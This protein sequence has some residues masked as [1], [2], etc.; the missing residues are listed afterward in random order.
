MAY[1]IRSKE[2][3]AREL[4]SRGVSRFTDVSGGPSYLLCGVLA[5]AA[6]LLLLIHAAA[7]SDIYAVQFSRF[8]GNYA[9]TE[10]T[11]VSQSSEVVTHRHHRKHGRT[12]TTKETRYQTK[13]V[14]DDGAEFIFSGTHNYGGK[15]GKIIIKY[16]KSEPRNY[17]VA[18]DF[19]HMPS[20]RSFGLVILIFAV[21]TFFGTYAAFRQNRKCLMAVARGLYLP[22]L[23]TS[24]CEERTV[25][26]STYS[27]RHSHNRSHS[28]PHKEYAP[29]FRYAMPDGTEL[30][31]QGKW[32][33][34]WPDGEAANEDKEFRVYMMDPEDPDNNEYFIKEIPRKVR[35]DP[36]V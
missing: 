10:A 20:D 35:A 16:S 34:E 6:V 8:T 25:Q 17:Y 3:L 19:F 5:A 12:T 23:E 36:G 22:V 29:I 30:L 26:T 18:A 1:I 11:V 9:E 27:R 28:G 24:H 7:F 2:D 21:L 4:A 32:S 15:G 31:F 33:C 14:S 13:A